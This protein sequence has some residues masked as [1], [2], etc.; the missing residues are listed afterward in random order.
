MNSHIVKWGNSLGIRIPMGL[1]KQLHL[2]AGSPV[3]LDVESG[4]IIIQ[5]PKYDL[6]TMV[7]EISLE[8]QPHQLL[9]DEQIGGEEW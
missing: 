4:C 1:A 7:K 5:A 2:H 3:N 8:N 9:E 6:E